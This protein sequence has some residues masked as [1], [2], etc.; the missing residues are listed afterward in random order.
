MGSRILQHLYS[1]RHVNI[2]RHEND[3]CFIEHF[4]QKFFSQTKN[5]VSRIKISMLSG[6]TR[7]YTPPPPPTPPNYSSLQHSPDSSVIE[8]YPDFTHSKGWTVW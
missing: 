2:Y 6:G 5:G 8:E 1:R 7:P 3:N 4:R